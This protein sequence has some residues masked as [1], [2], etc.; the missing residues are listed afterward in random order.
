MRRS[1]FSMGILPLAAVVFATLG[2]GLE[3]S[4]LTDATT[5]DVRD[6]DGIGPHVCGNGRVESVEECDDGNAI[7]GDGCESNCTFSCHDNSECDDGNQCT[8]DV[9]SI[10]AGGRDC[11]NR[12]VF[13]MDCDDGNPCT[14]IEA[15]NHDSC[16][17]DPPVCVPGPNH[18]Q[19]ATT[20]DCAPFD[21]ADRCNGTLMCDGTVC[22]P[23]PAT[24]VPCPT[25]GDPP[26]QD[27]WCDPATGICGLINEPDGNFC[28]DGDW[29]STTEDC[30]SGACTPAEQRCTLAC[31]LCNAGS[32][33]C[34]PAPGWCII[35]SECVAD[36]IK[37][38]ANPCQACQPGA[39]PWN[40]TNL[41]PGAD[42]SDGSYCNG[43]ETCDSAGNC[44][45]GTPPCT[46]SGCVG[47]CNDGTDSCTPAG[48]STV[49]RDSTG[50]CDPAEN[51]T[52]S[53]TS[54]PADELYAVGYEC[55]ASRGDCDVAETCDGVGA[56]C[57][58][59]GRRAAGYVCREA[60]D[61]CDRRETCT[62]SADSCPADG[63]L[64][65]GTE[66]R[67]AT[68]DCG[69]AEAC[70]G[71]SAACPGDLHATSG[72]CRPAAGVCDVAES[73]NGSSADCPADLYA[74][75]GECRAVN[76]VCDVAESC[77]GSSANC[78][79]DGFNTGRACRPGGT[80]NPG[81]SC[82]GTSASCP[83]DV[84]AADGD[85]CGAS[86]GG[87]CCTG[88]CHDPGNC[89]ISADC[90]DGNVGFNCSSNRCICS[91]EGRPCTGTEHCCPAGGG[92]AGQ[93]RISAC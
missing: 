79:A 8:E 69:L 39:D 61:V 32:L 77:N 33:S 62:G 9:C 58:A 34:D 84:Q 13:G 91:V 20:P 2:C 93:C 88:T 66:C 54:C 10:V 12:V 7:P 41:G 50:P 52:G 83:A 26:C 75:S 86:S 82:D 90:T 40:Y 27:S 73:C 17:G 31:A 16:E 67:P 42:C 3:R 35:G 92:H 21:D 59:D 74:T 38:P 5:G 87:V 18:C 71:S 11:F 68:G 65:D 48:I 1:S 56:G 23:D 4:G 63:F 14:Y 85:P 53:S 60:A 29:C 25:T 57:P 80:C 24:V 70:T 64:P 30:R 28:N 22:V 43:P 76:G 36:G 37:N 78:P 15:T 19:C 46:V 47:G 6:G 51:C 55:R 72:A 45:P 44:L 49:C 89:C 81:E